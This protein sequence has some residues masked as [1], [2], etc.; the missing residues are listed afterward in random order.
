MDDIFPATAMPD[1]TWWQALWPH[2][3][4]VLESLGVKPGMTVADLCCGDG[5][6]TAPLARVAKAVIA[7][8]ADPSM[9]DLAR[10]RI[11][12]D[13]LTNALFVAGDAYDLA[14]LVGDPVD[15]VLLA[16]TFHGVPDKPR[17]ARAAAAALK[18]GG[19]FAIVNWHRLPR[20]ETTV[21][22]LPRGPRIE[23]RMTP[24]EVAAVIEPAG[25]RLVR[26]VEL[27]PYHYGAI[28]ETP[29]M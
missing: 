24:Q 28:F 6:F 15:F 7:I 20:E 10:A 19:W 23:M 9:L 14:T 17:L 18:P 27:L 29:A 11:E 8:D 21:L 3:A 4:R 2:L 16:N 25:F 13:G 22:G 26:V 1:P 5:L 12:A